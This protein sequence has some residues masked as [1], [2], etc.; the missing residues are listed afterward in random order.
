MKFK[1]PNKDSESRFY[2]DGRLRGQVVRKPSWNYA[3]LGMQRHGSGNLHI[4]G[5]EAIVGPKGSREIRPGLGLGFNPPPPPSI[6]SVLC[7]PPP[8]R[9]FNAIDFSA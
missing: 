3:E 5:S 4:D 7:Q 9:R 8:P 2:A 1:G 6:P